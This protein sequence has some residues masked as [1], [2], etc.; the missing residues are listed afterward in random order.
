VRFELDQANKDF[1]ALNKE[2]ATLR[3]VRCPHHVQGTSRAPLYNVAPTTQAKKDSTAL[4]EKSKA[5]KQTMLD[6]QEKEKEVI[7]AREAALLPI[8]NLVHDTVPISD[9]EVACLAV[10]TPD[11]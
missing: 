10:H 8:G 11:P 1:N 4:Q 9:N 6:I 7:S 5:L 3:K 2:I